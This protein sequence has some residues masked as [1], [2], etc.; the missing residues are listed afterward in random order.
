MAR[1]LIYDKTGKQEIIQSSVSPCRNCDM[2]NGAE[3]TY[4]DYYIKALEA[5]L[6]DMDAQDYASGKMLPENTMNNFSELCNIVE[7]VKN[8]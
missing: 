7:G 5:G 1:W 4:C 3:I 8:G 6:R 2:C